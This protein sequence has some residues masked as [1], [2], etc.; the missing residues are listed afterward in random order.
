M[1]TKTDP[2]K[3]EDI[4]ERGVEKIIN[5]DHL[6][7][8]LF[9]GKVLRVKHGI[10]PTGPDIHLGRAAQLLKLKAFQ[11]LGHKIVLIIGDFTA[12]IGD[13]SDKPE[14][15]RGLTLK[16]IENNLSGYLKQF[17]KILDIKKTEIRYNSEWFEKLKLDELLNVV[18][19]FSVQQLVH[20]RNFKQRWNEEKPIYL[21]EI[22]YPI[23][24]GYDSVMV[25]ADVEL[26]GYDQLFNLKMGR[27][28]QEMHNQ[29]PQDIVTLKMLPGTD[30][31]K[32]STS[33]GNVVTIVED[34]NNMYGKI[35][36]MKDELIPLYFEL[37]TT[38]PLQEIKEIEKGMKGGKINPRDAKARL[39]FEIVAFYHGKTK[40]K[41]AE[42]E[43]V[44]VFKEKKE[45]QK[46]RKFFA[47]KKEYPIVELLVG[48]GFAK[49]KSDA[50]RLIIQG[51]V[52]IDGKVQKDWKQVV[53]IKEG[54]II[55][56]GKLKFAQMTFND[57]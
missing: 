24:Q 34:P 38:V 25:K 4:L 8:A 32:M 53:K 10:D 49:S 45:P 57:R 12:Q 28:L 17:S 15:R 13:P 22:L 1:K 37:C 42:K 46:I 44:R 36:S 3:I 41:E 50:K 29:Q 7:K 20:R 18:K 31:R 14:G 51:G 27:T 5:K 2:K 11:D 30:G 54:M 16:E 56:V 47:P 23:F 26:G 48:L 52:K 21:P 35:M 55:Q 43:F 19:N 39:A 9:S 6:K 40:A 33:W